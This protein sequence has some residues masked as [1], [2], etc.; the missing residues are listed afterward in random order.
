MANERVRLL[1]EAEGWCCL[2][3]Y[4]KAKEYLPPST[5]AYS[6]RVTTRAMQKWK[7]AY[8]RGDCKCAQR[9]ECMLR[10]VGGQQEHSQDS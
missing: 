4:L 3:A 1:I 2:Y 10:A 6:L 5:M 8:K 9:E 7:E